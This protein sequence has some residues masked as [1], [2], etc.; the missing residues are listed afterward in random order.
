MQGTTLSHRSIDCGICPLGI[1]HK[2]L[3]DILKYFAS[4]YVGNIHVHSLFS[5]G[6]SKV[7][8]I[9]RSAEKAGLDFIIFNEHDHMTD[10]LHLESEGFHRGVLVFMGLEIGGRHH[11]YLAFDL[12]EMIRGNSLTPQEVIDQ[13]NAQGGFGC[14]AQQSVACLPGR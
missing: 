4:E 1:F 8:E 3:G 6:A 14:L 9:T 10:D 7:S 13:V 12:K 11:H 5:D 2:R